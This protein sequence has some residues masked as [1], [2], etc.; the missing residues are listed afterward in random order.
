MKGKGFLV[1]LAVMAVTSSGAVLADGIYKSTDADGTVHYVDR[2]TGA[3]T[4]ER[5]ALSYGRTDN[6][7]VQSRI[8]AR[9]DGQAAREEAR[10]AAADEKK[11]AEEKKAEAAERQKR[12]DTYRARLEKYV[13]SRRLYRKDESGEREYLD[14]QQMQDARQRVEDLV[15]ENCSP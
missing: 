10:S 12:C 2:P 9:V 5:L 14:E 6:S 4:E 15:A 7:A 1:G 11:S 3:A 13:Q 8:Q